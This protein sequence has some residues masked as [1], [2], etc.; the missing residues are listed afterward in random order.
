MFN[1]SHTLDLILQNKQLIEKY[2]I[3]DDLVLSDHKTIV[4]EVTF[5]IEKV[6]SKEKRKVLLFKKGK[7]KIINWYLAQYDWYNIFK[8]KNP[9]EIAEI[10]NSIITQVIQKFI[11]LKKFGEKTPMKYPKEIREIIKQKAYAWKKLKLGEISKD[12]YKSLEI[13]CKLQIEKYKNN[14][15]SK[16]I[17]S[18]HI[19][20]IHKLMKR[21]RYKF[22]GIPLLNES[23]EGDPIILDT[24]KANKFRNIFEEIVSGGKNNIQASFEAK[25]GYQKEIIF[26][27]YII[28]KLLKKL[29]NKLSHSPENINQYFLK[30]CATPLALPLSILYEN[31]FKTGIVPELWKTAHILPIFKKKGSVNDPKN[32]RPIALTS[33]TCRVFERI[34]ANNI[35]E[36]LYKH[37]L[38]AEEQFGFLPKSSCTLQILS[39]MQDWY[40]SLDRKIGTDVIYFDFE[41]AFDK[42]DH[43]ILIRKLQEI[44]ID[45]LTIRWIANFLSNRSHIVKIDDHFSEPFLPKTGVPQGTV[46]GPLL[47]LIYIN[48][49]PKHIP[50]NIK[51]KLYADD[52]KLYSEINTEKDCIELQ[53]AINNAYRWA[54][55]N[56]L[57]F[58]ISKVKVL[59]IYNKIKY[60]YEI[61]GD[62]IEEVNNIRDLGVYIDNKLKFD[63]HVAKITKSSFIRLNNILRILPKTLPIDTYVKAFKTYVRPIME[64]STESFSPK[65]EY[66]NSQLERPQRSFT[67]KILRYKFKYQKIGYTERLKRC[68]LPPTKIRR[69]RTDL[70]TTFKIINGFYKIKPEQ[71]FSKPNRNNLRLH[72]YQIFKKQTKNNHFF[73]HRVIDRWNKLPKNE[74][75]KISTI[76][77]FKKFIDNI[78]ITEDPN[79]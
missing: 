10:L 35:L 16:K 68:K 31:T 78:L 75:E 38:I 24:D 4:F 45:S 22:S 48:D 17:G 69:I 58:S 39:S 27:P 57:D 6:N 14:Y 32:Y 21:N 72:R 5:P 50:K 42:V 71:M 44:K 8:D 43:Q 29:P 36:H 51:V 70:M 1:N 77:Q 55:N 23:E 66:L 2:K 34:I 47:F 3:I 54:K 30:K 79:L 73:S 7:Y 20:E 26:E 60:N 40:N 62:K 37:K 28:E 59:K 64:Y 19:G 53:G 12:N 67:R 46:L 76:P 25:D 13:K 52:F 61:N 15:L 18:G 63:Q 11:P 65:L 56:R 9:S 74:I 33:P 41:K 49:L